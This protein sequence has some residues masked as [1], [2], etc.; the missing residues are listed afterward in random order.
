MFSIPLNAYP[1][2]RQRLHS[3]ALLLCRHLGAECDESARQSA[4]FIFNCP[5]DLPRSFRRRRGLFQGQATMSSPI[6]CAASPC[7]APISF[8]TW[9]I[10]NCRST[11]AARPAIAA[12]SRTWPA[13]ASICGSA[14]TRPGRYSKAHKHGSAA[15]LICLRAR[16]IPIRGRRRSGTHAVGGRQARPGHARRITNPVGMVIGRADER[17]LV[18]PAFRHQQG[19]AAVQR[20]VRSEQC[21]RASPAVRATSERTRARSTSATAARAIPYD[22]EDPL[23]RKEYEEALKGVGATS[24]MEDW[25]YQRPKEG[26][27][28][29]MADFVGI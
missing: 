9:S 17:R 25:L 12:S 19:S 4:K 2:H 1:P 11:T 15:V 8:P 22:E 13:T 21:A 7:A 29:P 10:A 20:L 26:E 3:P 23:I 27:V 24:R 6:R 18:P 16:A 28:R 5:Y 14:S